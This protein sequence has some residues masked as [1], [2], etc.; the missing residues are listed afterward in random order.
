ME[1]ITYSFLSSSCG[2]VIGAVDNS[3]PGRRGTSTRNKEKESL[4]L[5][6]I[7]SL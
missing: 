6:F 2:C 3:T 5:K 4:K 7:W 1:L